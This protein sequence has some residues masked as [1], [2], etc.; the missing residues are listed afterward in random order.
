LGNEESMPPSTTIANS[1]SSIQ[2]DK[3]QHKTCQSRGE[4]LWIIAQLNPRSNSP[5]DGD[6]LH[7][8]KMCEVASGGV[9]SIGSC[10]LHANGFF[11]GNDEE[12]LFYY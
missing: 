3:T 11:I 7:G 6:I 8:Q 4:K 12:Y 5:E 10:D 2:F 9:L 1:T